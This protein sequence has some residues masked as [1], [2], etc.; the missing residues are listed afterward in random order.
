M[1][2]NCLSLLILIANIANAQTPDSIIK[3]VQRQYTAEKIYI[4]YDQPTYIA[5]ETIWFKAYIMQ[6]IYPSQKSTVIKISLLNNEGN[7]I[8]EKIL[9]VNGGSAVG[10]F[11][12]PDTLPQGNYTVKATT[13]VLMNYGFTNYYYKNID[14]YNPKAQAK[15]N[16]NVVALNEPT[17]YFLPEG[18]N[19]VA[20]IKSIIAIKCADKK[21]LPLAAT[22]KIYTETGQE[23][24]TFA[25][26]HDGMG[27]FEFVPKLGEKY[28]AQ[29]TINNSTLNVPLP[30][31][32]EQG[33]TIETEKIN[34]NIHFT[35]NASTILNDN[36]QPSYLL[37]VQENVVVCK[38]PLQSDNK[39]KIGNIPYSLLTT[40]ILQ[41]TV[42]NAT[43]TPLLERLVFINT[44]DYIPEGKLIP[45]KIGLEA[46]EK[47]SFTYQIPDSLS[48]TFSVSVTSTAFEQTNTDNLISRLLLT[49]DI[50][51]IVHNP[52]Y[53]FESND[54]VHQKNLDLVMLT[55]GWT[56]YKWS[57]IL[58]NI[59]PSM[60]FKDPNYITLKC[61]ATDPANGNPLA[62][63]DLSVIVKTADGLADYLS[64]P[65]DEKGYFELGNMTFEDTCSFVFKNSATISKR[66]NIKMISNKI[67][68]ILYTPKTVLP[69]TYFTIPDANKMMYINDRYAF[70]KEEKYKTIL[71]DEIKIQAKKKS[72]KEK[73]EK[74]YVSGRLGNSAIREIDFLKEPTNSNFNVFDYLQNRVAG[75]QVSGGPFDY[76]LNYRST[77]SLSGGAIP[78]AIFLDE[79]QVDASQVATLKIT[80]VALIKVYNIGGL[81]GGTGGA[82]A[83]YTKK[84]G[85][86]TNAANDT[87]T[88]VEGFTTTKEFFSPDY[89]NTEQDNAKIDNRTTLYWNPYLNLSA[90][91]N[92]FSFSFYNTD[93]PKK[94]KIVLEGV[95]EDG[96]LLHI[97]KTI[98][99]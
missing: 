49:A 94:Y 97:E 27:K 20:N 19:F 74:E 10:Q 50:K 87:P 93:N 99:N 24:V 37:G 6:G 72:E 58:T 48:G 14:I 64:V 63:K 7:N 52:A 30:K 56:K 61:I 4:H 62:K 67:S 1:F 80:E 84:D 13:V 38:I 81:A 53:Y 36:L 15:L 86:S 32:M 40:G 11:S 55:H 3:T 98:E 42:F 18:G 45:N 75:I 71:L 88:W 91:K 12:L 41:L 35:L 78:M 82:V 47:N 44:G 69:P 90:A 28:T 57:E 8:Q 65:T 95:Y 54:E 25:T 79:F 46:R 43:H 39:I 89:S 23:V 51:G 33:L 96:K 29:C 83:I 73:Y 85:G 5:G 76:Q 92:N 34:N 31:L 77:R 2:R 17:I 16:D 70:N 26:I 21:G 9:P 68:N 22:G 59:F 66:A 60:A